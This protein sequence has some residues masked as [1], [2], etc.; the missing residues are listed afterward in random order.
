MS[1]WILHHDE[2]YFQ[3]SQKFDP[4]RWLDPKEA[5]RIEKAFVPFSKGSR[6]CVGMKYATSPDFIAHQLTLCSNS[7]AYC[8]LYATLGT[9]FRRFENL[10]SNVLTDE[11]RAYNDY[12]SGQHPLDATKFHVTQVKF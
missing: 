5:R 8:E 11:D 10:K 9:V 7:L 12:F 1:S 2:K 3:N 6:A 4:T